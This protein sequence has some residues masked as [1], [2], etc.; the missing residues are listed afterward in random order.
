VS[1]APG[2]IEIRVLGD[3]ALFSRDG[4]GVSYLVRAGG[5]RLLLECG[6]NPFWQLGPE[7]VAGLSGVIVTHAHFDHHRY[8]T[9]LALYCRYGTKRALPVLATEAVARDLRECSSPALVRTLSDDGCRIIDVPYS[10]F[11][12]DVRLGPRARYRLEGCTRGGRVS[13]RAVD[14]KTGRPVSTRRAKAV[15]GPPGTAPRLLVFDRE[16]GEWVDPEDFYCFAERAFYLGGNRT[17]RCAKSGLVV[18]AI[19]AP[20]WHGP[21]SAA[22]LLRRGAAKAAFS[23]DTVYDPDL[24]TRLAERKLKQRLPGSRKSFL[25]AEEL[26]VPVGRLVERVWS[27]RRLR[28]ALSAYDGAVVF[29]DADYPGSVVH[30]IYAKL[31]AAAGGAAARWKGLVLTHTPELFTSMHP[32]ACTG[33]TF[34]VTSRGLAGINDGP[35]AWHKQDG[36]VYGLRKSRGGRYAIAFTEGG[37]KLERL[38]GGRPGLEMKL[39]NDLG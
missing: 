5:T 35:V 1:A 31:S 37:L 22:I 17:W 11:V 2:G 33:A 26:R 30:T 28:E 36:K 27:R 4:K 34:R 6:A 25:A 18:Q 9:E 14:A 10:R 7:G 19:K 21:N 15:T 8:L 32:I 24:W 12:R 16:Y 39:I 20:S 29:H 38:R 3:S 23:S 13:W